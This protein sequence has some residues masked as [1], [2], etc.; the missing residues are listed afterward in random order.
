ME[1]MQDYQECI[2]TWRASRHIQK[3]RVSV[4]VYLSDASANSER[5]ASKYTVSLPKLVKEKFN[6]EISQWEEFWSRYTAIHDNG[7]LC[8]KGKF[9]YLKSYLTGAA[10]RAIAGLAMADG[11]YDAA[12]EL[13]QNR[14]GR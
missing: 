2:L 4:S 8:K 1:I 13:L 9:T 3:E 11:N 10:A 12:I 5:P 7:A 14:F 6:R